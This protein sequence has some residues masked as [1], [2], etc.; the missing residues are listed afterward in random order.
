VRTL[1]LILQTQKYELATPF[2]VEGTK[3]LSPKTRAILRRETDKPIAQVFHKESQARS[4]I[5]N[6]LDHKYFIPV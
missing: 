1:I 2:T 6:D 4:N 5:D 3:S